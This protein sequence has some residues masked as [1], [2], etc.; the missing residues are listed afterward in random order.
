MGSM[1]PY[2]DIY[3]STMD[4]SWECSSSPQLFLFR[5]SWFKIAHVFILV[6]ALD[7]AFFHIL[8][9]SNNPN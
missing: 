4:P 5:S 2:I 7:M 1:L 6:G 9:I 8:G 3:S